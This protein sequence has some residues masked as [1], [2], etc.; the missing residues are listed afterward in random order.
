MAA[1]LFDLPENQAEGAVDD[2]TGKG[3]DDEIKPGLGGKKASDET[4]AGQH[5]PTDHGVEAD[6]AEIAFIGQFLPQE[7]ELDQGN[8][9]F[10]QERSDDRTHALHGRDQAGIDNQVYDCAA[11]NA[12]DEDVERSLQAGMNAHLSKPI[13][14]ERMYE[15]LAHLITGQSAEG[16]KPSA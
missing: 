5:D 10:R 7:N 8:G 16:Q 1:L 12:F 13:E 3:H 4:D 2:D 11:A 6:I 9:K 15:T 14:P